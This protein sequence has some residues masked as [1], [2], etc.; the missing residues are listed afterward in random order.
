MIIYLLLVVFGWMNIYAVNLSTNG[1]FY[2]DLGN[3]YTMQLVWIVVCLGIAFL[4]F[5]IDSR[6]YSFI[7]YGVFAFCVFLLLLVLVFGVEINNSKS[8]LDLGVFSLQPS[9]FAKLGVI[10][11]LAKYLSGYQIKNILFKHYVV[12]LGLVALPT[13]LIALQPDIG[14]TMV[15]GAFLL[16]L[17]REGLPGWILV[18]ILVAILVFLFSLFMQHFIIL[19]LLSYF[20][21]LAYLI[22]YRNYKMFFRSV[23]IFTFF[24]V[25]SLVI[26]NRINIHLS[27][28]LFVFSSILLATLSVIVLAIMQ[29]SRQIILF[30]AILFAFIGYTYTVDFI[31]NDILKEHQQKRVKIMLGL[32]SDPYGYEYNVRQSKIAIGSGG[33]TGKGFLKGTQTKYRF[34]PEQ[35]TDFIFCTVGEEWGFLGSFFLVGLFVSLFLRLIYLAERQRSRFSRVFGYGVLCVMFFHFAVNIAMTIGLFPVI[36]IPLPFLSYGGSSLLSFTVMLFIFLKLDSSR[37][38]YLV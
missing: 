22:F 36:G 13:M 23:L 28:F 30:L 1:V 21:L 16:V 9:E 8:W 37:K 10:M 15:F 29:K 6:L 27:K 25:T 17:F 5:L 20:V 11:V 26:Y 18:A 35:S 7:A 33:F 3:R 19:I 14:S 34:V 24:I 12:A 38:M 31:F 2:F 4:L 32:E